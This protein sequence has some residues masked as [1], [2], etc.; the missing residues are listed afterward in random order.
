MTN[1]ESVQAITLAP[2]PMYGQS[3]AGRAAVA[4]VA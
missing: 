3:L 1:A 2:F 4:T